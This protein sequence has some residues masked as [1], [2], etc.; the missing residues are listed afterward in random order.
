MFRDHEDYQKGFNYIA[1]AL[2]KTNSNGLVEA[3]M[4]THL[5]LLVQTE[6]TKE[7]MYNFRNSYSKYFNHKYER[8]GRLGEKHHFSLDVVGYNHILAAA[9]YVLRNPLHH[10]VAPI[11]Y[12]Y[13]HCTASTIFSKEMGHSHTSNLLPKKSYYRHLGRHAECPESYKMNDSGIFLRESV[14]DI[15][16]VE[17]LFGT[18]RAFNYFMNRRTSEEWEKEQ[19]KDNNNYP[20]VNL[21][22]IEKGIS[23]NSPEKM[24]I[25]EN[26]R[27]DYKGKSD[28]DLCTEI[29]LIAR[30]RF[31]K[32]SVYQLSNNEKQ[33]IAKDLS[34]NHY[35]SHKQ[36]CRCLALN[37]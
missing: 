25:L 35:I 9:S 32:H 7:L 34:A 10:G 27:A 14:L 12:G 16:Q 37:Q 33:I 15:S 30:N 6:N 19:L 20:P 31:T 4:S 22:S 11:P 8:E 23:L 24:L 26:G 21:L 5:H 36:I 28:I 17:N 18:P 3:I 29:D 2:H 13:P 1:L